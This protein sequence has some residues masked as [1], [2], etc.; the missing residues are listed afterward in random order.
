MGILRTKKSQEK[1]SKFIANGFLGEECNLCSEKKAKS[2]KKFKHWRIINNRFPHD[3]I[4]KIN[5][6]LIPKRHTL[7]EKLNK[8]EKE[9]FEKIKLNYIEEKYDVLLEATKKRKSIPEHHHIHL[10]ILKK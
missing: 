5:H 9:E 4:S 6:I 10:I 8:R 2:L 1:Y 7:Y 3:R